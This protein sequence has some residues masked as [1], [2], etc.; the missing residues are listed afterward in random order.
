MNNDSPGETFDFTEVTTKDVE[1]ILL[2][3]NPRK[4]PE[5]DKLHPRIL[6]L[7]AREIGTHKYL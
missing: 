7:C 3:L 5:F 6:K 2:H 1:D 4:A